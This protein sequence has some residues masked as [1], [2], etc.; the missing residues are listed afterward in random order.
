MAS[1]TADA[2]RRAQR[3]LPT[4]YY[5]EHFVEMLAFI[6]THYAHALLDSHRDF[7]EKYRQL[8]LDAQRLYVRLVNRKGRVFARARLRYPEIGSLDAPQAAHAAGLREGIRLP[9]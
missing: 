7:I 2:S 8:P 3:E 6:S 5:H 1:H 4:Y 9:E